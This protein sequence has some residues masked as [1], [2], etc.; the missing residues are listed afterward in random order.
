V[1]SGRFGNAPVSQPYVSTGRLPSPELVKSLVSECYERL[2]ANKDGRNSEV[3]PALGDVPQDLLG[4]C[5]V[6]VN[7][8][9]YASGDWDYPFSI[10]SVS[11]PFVF[12]LVCQVLGG[13]LCADAWASTP[14]AFRSTP[15]RPSNAVRM[16]G[17]IQW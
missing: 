11:K 14:P 3:Y 1:N 13:M 7:G 15:W 8:S 17:R 12:A 2:K 16:D 9:V 6:S 5:V 10:M 4:L